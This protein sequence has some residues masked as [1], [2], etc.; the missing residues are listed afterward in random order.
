M[1][2]VLCRVSHYLTLV[3]HFGIN[4][5]KYVIKNR[6]VVLKDGILKAKQHGEA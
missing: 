6:K 4:P 1:D 5:I 3:C 2:L